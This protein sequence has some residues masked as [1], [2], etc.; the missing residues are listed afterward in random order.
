MYTMPYQFLTI[1]TSVY[2]STIY[3]GFYLLEDRI[4]RSRI[5]LKRE[6][7]GSQQLRVCVEHGNTYIHYALSNLQSGYRCP[8]YDMS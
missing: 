5:G 3:T 8:R 1:Y 7:L 4:D 6:L 2:P